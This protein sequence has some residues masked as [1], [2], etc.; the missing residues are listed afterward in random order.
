MVLLTVVLR[1]SYA[2]VPIEACHGVPAVHN[3]ETK[4]GCGRLVAEA[5][6]VGVT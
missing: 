2:T 6:R 3:P 5:R 1:N 4:G